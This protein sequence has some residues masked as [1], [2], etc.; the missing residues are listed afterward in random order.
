MSVTPLLIASLAAFLSAALLVLVARSGIAALL[1]NYA[2]EW[3]AARRRNAGRIAAIVT[4]LKIVLVAETRRFESVE[5]LH[6]RLLKD[7]AR[8]NVATTAEDYLAQSLFEG[9]AFAVGGGIFCLVLMGPVAITIPVFM[10]VA[11][12]LWVRPSLVGSDGEKR[13]RA[14]Y[15][16]IPYALDLGVLVLQAGGTLREALEQVAKGGGA[17]AEEIR[18]VL[19]EIDS[20]SSQATALKNMSNRVRLDVLETIVL[21]INR[22]EETGAPM[23]ETLTTQAQMF[24]QRRLQ[25]LEKLAVEAPTKMTFPNMMVMLS[26]LVIIIGPLLMRISTSGMF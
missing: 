13:T 20:G 16:A 23:A 7:V 24:R 10:G 26:V 4:F 17:L 1:E 14:I 11:W 25:E 8:A 19:K 2:D 3:T 21:A 5:R 6:A 15:R 9:F 18:I 22:G 12:A